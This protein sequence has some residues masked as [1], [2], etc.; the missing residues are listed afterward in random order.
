MVVV[1]SG[2]GYCFG[3]RLVAKAMAVAAEVGYSG[4]EDPSILST[5]VGD[6]LHFGY[7]SAYYR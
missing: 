5:V 2:V 3:Q 1:D 7:G 4:R 6:W